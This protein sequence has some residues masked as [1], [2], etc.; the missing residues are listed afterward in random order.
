MTYTK[1]KSGLRAIERDL[2]KVETEL[3]SSLPRKAPLTLVAARQAEIERIAKYAILSYLCLS[4][5]VVDK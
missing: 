4:S 3:L 2:T 1:F 5:N